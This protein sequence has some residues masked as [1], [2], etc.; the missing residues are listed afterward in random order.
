MGHKSMSIRWLLLVAIAIGL[1]LVISIWL[2]GWG[3]KETT[4]EQQHGH[5][6][7]QPDMLGFFDVNMSKVFAY[8]PDTGEKGVIS[9]S[10][11]EPGLVNIYVLHARTRELYLAKLVNWEKRDA[12]KHTESWDGKDF[13]GHIV[14]PSD[15]RIIIKGEKLSSYAPGS[16]PIADLPEEEIIHG[17]K[18][19]HAHATHAESAEETPILT[20]TSV[21][22][23]DIL[24]GRV[25][26][27]AEVDKDKR[28]YGD[29]YGYGVRYYVDETLA[30]EEFYK[31]E[32]KGQFNYEL[33]TTA[34]PDGE[35]MLY[36]G[37]CDHNQHATS[38]GLKVKFDNSKQSK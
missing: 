28:G 14:K 22:D 9:Y 23:G 29:K 2:K 36:L 19:G 34:F 10:I 20:I 27:K 18:W 12:G 26:I 1:A 8:Y 3:G 38:S 17:H 37:M 31:P 32:C 4:Q 7:Q 13:S 11:K 24:G 21:R 30:Q 25:T 35:H 16:M 33:D 5:D 15:A 6:H